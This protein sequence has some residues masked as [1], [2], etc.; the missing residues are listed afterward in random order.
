MIQQKSG[1]HAGNMNAAISFPNKLNHDMQKESQ[2]P[3][4]APKYSI[5]EYLKKMPGTKRT[6]CYKLCLH[7]EIHINTLHKWMNIQKGE[8]S[9]IPV[10]TFYQIAEFLNVNPN[11]LING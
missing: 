4:P 11:D 1:I 6:N 7:L 2:N 10:D 5:E 9:S 8:K 3:T